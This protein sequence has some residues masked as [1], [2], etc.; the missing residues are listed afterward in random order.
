MRIN[1]SIKN[2]SNSLL[3]TVLNFIA[4]FILR[5]VFIYVL[6]NELLGLNSIFINIIGMLSLA[7]L[8]VGTAIGYSLY[9]P[10]ADGNKENIKSLMYLYKK[11]YFKIG[12]AVLGLGLLLIPFLRIFITDINL[13]EHTY[14]YYVVF[15]LSSVIPYFFSYKRTLIIADQKNYKLVKYTSF[16]KILLYILQI[17]VLLISKN[18]LLFLI[19][20]VI[21]VIFENYIINSFINRDY[22]YLTSKNVKKVSLKDKK[23]ISKNVKA[24]V[25]HKVGDYAVNGTDNIIIS[26]FLGLALVGLYANYYLLITMAMTFFT[27]V[28]TNVTASFGNL[29]ASA[30]EEVVYDKFKV[31]NFIGTISFGFVTL[32]LL[33]LINPFIE[34]WIGGKYLIDFYIVVIIVINFYLTLLRVPLSVAKSSAGLYDEDKYVPLIQAVV[35]LSV[36]LIL[37]NIIGLAGVFIGTLVSSLFVVSWLRPY[38]VYKHVF[39]RSVRSYYLSEIFNLIVVL[40]QGLFIYVIINFINIENTILNAIVIFIVILFINVIF[41]LIFYRKRK[42]FVVV[43]DILLNNVLRRK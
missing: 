23:I 22:P 20:Q 34:L 12:L 9:K 36:S 11:L 3:F 33:F 8:G 6:G 16:F 1:N 15:L 7:E 31:M 38:I 43:K 19:L 39:K 42:E 26:A 18:Y 10:L 2:I 21:V 4:N 30:D 28:F 41:F 40:S 14:I 29:I 25:W 32:C 13:F 24:M 27:I 35:N 37:V 17:G 5:T